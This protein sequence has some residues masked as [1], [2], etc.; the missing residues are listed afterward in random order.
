MAGT[1]NRPFLVWRGTQKGYTGAVPNPL[2]KVFE[3]YSQDEAGVWYV[4]EAF[5]SAAQ[6][7]AMLEEAL[8]NAR[9]VEEAH[10]LQGFLSQVYEELSFAN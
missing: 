1:G 7:K 5:D 3:L 2:R 4:A 10:R 6:A 9:T 8:D